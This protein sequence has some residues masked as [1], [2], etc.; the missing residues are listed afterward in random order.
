MAS[1]RCVAPLSYGRGPS[2]TPCPI[3]ASV[4]GCGLWQ[5]RGCGR[6]A[7]LSRVERTNPH[8]CANSTVRG[9]SRRASTA[10]IDHR[11]SPT[12]SVARNLTRGLSAHRGGEVSRLCLVSPDEPGSPGPGGAGGLAAPRGVAARRRGVAARRG[13]PGRRPSSGRPRPRARVRVSVH[14]SVICRMRRHRVSANM[15]P[16][17]IMRA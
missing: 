11:R 15:R 1:R 13:A 3:R 16:R 5:R 4:I 7:R 17:C 8:L 9:C 12:V 10:G 14:T 6:L 2:G